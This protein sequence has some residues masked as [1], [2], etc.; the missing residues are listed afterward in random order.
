MNGKGFWQDSVCWM[1]MGHLLSCSFFLA[2]A[3]ILFSTNVYPV[4][5]AGVAVVLFSLGI[6]LRQT[7]TNIISKYVA[8]CSILAFSSILLS[9]ILGVVIV[10]KLLLFL[11]MS[12][13]LI[14]FIG[15]LCNLE[16]LTAFV[17]GIVLF[18]GA[19]LFTLVWYD[20][21]IWAVF[22]QMFVFFLFM[23]NY[24]VA[25]AIKHN[26]HYIDAE[27]AIDFY[28]NPFCFIRNMEGA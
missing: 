10:K 18:V 17:L 26:D 8:F 1:I 23:V 15:Y 21:S 22:L 16:S 25:Y 20:F 12:F 6:V 9:L 3:I 5:V 2:Y 7:G 24:F 11:A 4:A 19:E 13:F 14:S 28:F 27:R